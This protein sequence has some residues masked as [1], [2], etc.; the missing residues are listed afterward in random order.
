MGGKTAH[1][2]KMVNMAMWLP[3]GSLASNSSENI[4]VFGLHFE[5]VFSNYQPFDF[6]ILD[7]IP[8]Q[9]QL[10]EIGRPINLVKLTRPSISSSEA[11]LRGSMASQQKDTRPWGGK[12]DCGFTITLANSLTAPE[13]T[14]DGTRANA[15]PFKKRVILLTPTSGEASCSWMYAAKSSAQL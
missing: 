13:E 5:R 15:F 6:S 14:M 2:K 1:H 9:E 11:K 12:F 8:Q 10:I 4:S 7:L 3:N